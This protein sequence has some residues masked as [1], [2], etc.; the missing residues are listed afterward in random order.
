MSGTSSKRSSLVEEATP[1]TWTKP[2]V[3]TY[4]YNQE[5][6]GN[7]YQPMMEFLNE[8]DKA[9]QFY[10]RPEEKIYLP[11]PAECGSD[12]YSNAR[13]ESKPVS[14]TDLDSFLVKAYS[15]QM[16]EQHKSMVHTQNEIVRP[17]T[18]QN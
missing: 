6:G 9:G 7:Y 13:L 14:L 1:S 17:S 2:R 3:K 15:R 8:K 10:M 5:F 11:D 12:K 18:I 4:E 16:K